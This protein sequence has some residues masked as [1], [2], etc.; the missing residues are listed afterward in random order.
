MK[1][2]VYRLA[3][4]AALAALLIPCALAFAQQAREVT[5]RSRGT[6]DT[7]RVALAALTNH[8]NCIK[9]L[10][11]T[12]EQ[13]GNLHILDA[14]TTIYTVAVPASGGVIED[15]DEADAPCTSAKNTAMYV[16]LTTATAYRLSYSA[17]T[18]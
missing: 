16:Y 4:R 3:C 18:Y 2:T 11:V 1:R 13:A 5:G 12:A 9:H 14:G 15:W 10:S 17:F 8:R 7:G 6:S